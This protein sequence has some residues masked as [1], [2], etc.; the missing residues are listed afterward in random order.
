MTQTDNHIPPPSVTAES[1]PALR[2]CLFSVSGARFA[3]DVRGAREVA[4]FEELTAVPR[5]P[6]PLVGVANL[7]GTV[8]P[9]IDVGPLLGRPALR[10]PRSVR[11]LVLR[12]G[13]LLAAMVVEAVLG[14]EPFETVLAAD[15]P[16]APRDR[17][18]SRLLT[19][20]VT[21][22]GETLPLLDA[23]RMLAELRSG[24]SSGTARSAA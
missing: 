4:L 7:R 1:T 19:G 6:R 18:P 21:W 2:A 3:V 8:I 17:V 10:T 14:L 11:T 16:T 15:A 12:D 13:P 22:A 5:A 9:I 24:S 20:W 23:G